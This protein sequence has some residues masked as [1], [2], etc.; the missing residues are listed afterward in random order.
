MGRPSRVDTATRKRAMKLQ[1]AGKTVR[2]IARTLRIPRSTIA[3][4]LSQKGKL[5]LGVGSSENLGSSRRRSSWLLP[6]HDLGCHAH[7]SHASNAMELGSVRSEAHTRF[8]LP[9]T[10]PA[11]EVVP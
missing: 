2:E 8:V 5:I 7:V 6:G 10:L 3:R 4:A 11:C 1:A 9:A